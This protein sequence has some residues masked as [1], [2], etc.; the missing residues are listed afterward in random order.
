MPGHQETLGLEVDFRRTFLAKQAQVIG[1]GSRQAGKHDRR[2]GLRA[3]N[4]DRQMIGHALRQ[5]PARI[6]ADMDIIGQAREVHRHVQQVAGVVAQQAAG[7]TISPVDAFRL[8]YFRTLL[9][10]DVQTGL[11]VDHPPQIAGVEPRNQLLHLGMEQL[12]EIRTQHQPPGRGA[13]VEIGDFPGGKR[14][15]LFDKDVDTTLQGGAGAF[16]V[17]CRRSNDVENID[18]RGAEQFLDRAANHGDLVGG[19]KLTDGCFVLIGDRNHL[20]A[21]Q[22]L[23][24]AGVIFRHPATT[25]NPDSQR[26]L[27]FM[28]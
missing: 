11:D 28:I 19:G 27:R 16:V 9:E 15:R 5:R 21:A 10:V 12:Q 3:V 17:E 18:F 8:Q 2:G 13:L 4:M 23:D 7:Q 26:C 6:P 1:G 22:T 20:S 14:H 24:E 25:D